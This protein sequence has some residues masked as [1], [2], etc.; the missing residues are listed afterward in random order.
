MP[1]AKDA[2]PEI[3]ADRHGMMKV[4]ASDASGTL[5]LKMLLGRKAPEVHASDTGGVIHLTA[6]TDGTAG[7]EP[8]SI[9]MT[10]TVDEVHAFV[11]DVNDTNALHKGTRPLVPGLLMVDRLLQV[12]SLKDC[13]N[14]SMRFT[15][16]VFIGQTVVI[17]YEPCLRR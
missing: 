17:T 4:Q 14:V 10:F 16:P 15:S 5:T 3:L 13:K 11:K 8:R 6:K 12:S 7:T 1:L 9:R 2:M